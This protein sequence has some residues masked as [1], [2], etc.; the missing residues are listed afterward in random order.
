MKQIYEAK[1]FV[2]KLRFNPAEIR[3]QCTGATCE[4]QYFHL[5]CPEILARRIVERA[6]GS[7]T[8]PSEIQSLVEWMVCTWDPAH[9]LEL[10]AND[11]RI[12]RLGVDVEFMPVP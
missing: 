12:D 1:T 8:I 2:K 7:P 6:K 10:V 4:G 11:I 9:R 5:N 3:A